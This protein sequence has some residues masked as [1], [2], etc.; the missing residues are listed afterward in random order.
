MSK[1]DDDALV[2]NETEIDI[3]LSIGDALKVISSGG[4]SSGGGGD[5]W[6]V[7]LS[8]HGF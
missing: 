6:I 3:G 7:T 1:T 8:D 2:V 4:P 5:L